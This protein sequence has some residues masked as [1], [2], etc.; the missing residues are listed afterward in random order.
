MWVTLSGGEGDTGLW[1][2]SLSM[3]STCAPVICASWRVRG[4]ALCRLEPEW[5]PFSP[6]DR[7]LVACAPGWGLQA[8]W[9]WLCQCPLRPLRLLIVLGLVGLGCPWP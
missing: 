1:G 2:P 7:T 6:G 9:G 8:P 3:W 4:R 5:F